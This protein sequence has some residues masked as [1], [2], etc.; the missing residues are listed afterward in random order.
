VAKRKEEKPKEYTRRQ[1]SHA[2]KEKLRQRIIFITAIVI[3]AAI[4][5]IPVIGWIV[6]EYYPMHQ[7]V[8]KVND[9]KYTM[10]DMIDY[11]KIGR[12]NDTNKEKDGW[13]LAGEALQYMQQ[14]EIM[15][16]GAAKLGITAS[17]NETKQ[18]LEMMGM[19]DDKAFEIY[20]GNQLIAAQLQNNYFGE[21][22]TKTADQVHALMMMLESDEQALEIREKL[23][24]GGNFTAL[25]EE[26]AQNYYSKNVNKGDFGWHIREV[27]KTMVG[28]DFPLDYAFSANAGDLSQ[29]ITDNETYKQW[30]YWLIKVVDR[31]EEG[32][33]NVQALLVSDK[34]LAKDIKSRLEANTAGLGDMADQYTQYS[35][36]KSTHGDIGV[37]STADNSTYTQAFN[38]YVWN[39]STPAGKWSEPILEEELWTRGGSWIVK[40]VEKEA[41]R[42]LNDED[43]S[44]LISEAFNFWFNKLSEDP[45]LKLE[46]NLV[47]EKMQEFAVERLEKEYPYQ[48]Q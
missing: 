38:D 34:A 47:T 44:Y 31:P 24:S 37:I 42:A 35:L 27:L 45:D 8:L 13:T 39:P 2:K 40:V 7:T 23:V 25:A 15:R 29:P 26:H 19:P 32:K 33:V 41:G 11:M 46:D 14:G 21:N 22:L 36:S 43:K 20:Y 18:Y 16:Q 6:T 9:V 10:R 5:L 12:A 3:V 4:I 30:G 17:D 48:G 1:L 28:T